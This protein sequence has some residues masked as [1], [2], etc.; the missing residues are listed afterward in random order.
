MSVTGYIVK[1]GHFAN[2]SPELTVTRFRRLLWAEADRAKIGRHLIN[3]PDCIN[4]GDGGVDAYIEGILP[5]NDDVIPRGSTVFQVKSADLLPNACRKELHAGGDTNRCLKK[6][7]NYRLK[8]GAAYVLVLFAEITVAQT[9]RRREAIENELAKFGY[10]NTEVRVFTA[11]HLAGFTN[12]HPSLV[13][14]LRPELSICSPYDRWGSSYDI[15]RP[16]AFVTDSARREKVK[17]FTETVRT[18]TTCPVIRVTG[19][20]GVGKTR[21]VYEALRDYDLS[22]QV[23]YVQRAADLVGS[24]LLQTLVNDPGMSA[25]LVVDECDIDDHRLLT[26]ALAGL[27]PRLALITMSYEVGRMQTPTVQLNTEPLQQETIEQILQQEYPGMPSLA[28]RRLAEFADG[29]PRIA[30]L[31]AAQAIGGS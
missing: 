25:I 28:V 18:R 22:N 29:Y 17:Q 24:S 30:D 2:L 26:N 31:L 10:A 5:A 6:E 11:N 1:P 19:L 3:V 23:L 14:S 20:P 7:L 9:R 4:V 27:G 13:S 12:R 15:R 21:S 8:Q 16:A